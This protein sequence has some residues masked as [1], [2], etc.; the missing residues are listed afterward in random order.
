VAEGFNLQGGLVQ[1]F[2]LR[3]GIVKDGLMSYH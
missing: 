2:F 1:D 3:V